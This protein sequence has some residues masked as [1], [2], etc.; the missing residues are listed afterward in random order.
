MG[1]VNSIIKFTQPCCHS[2]LLLASLD[3]LPDRFS[4]ENQP[5]SLLDWSN[6]THKPS[7]S[8]DLLSTQLKL[9]VANSSLIMFKTQG[10]CLLVDSILNKAWLFHYDFLFLPSVNCHPCF[11]TRANWRTGFCCCLFWGP[12]LVAHPEGRKR[13]LQ[14]IHQWPRIFS[15]LLSYTFGTLRS[16]WTFSNSIEP[17]G[18]PIGIFFIY[19]PTFYCLRILS[20]FCVSWSPFLSRW[21]TNLMK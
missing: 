20:A 14:P 10:I 18:W 6:W 15:L 17:V 1:E 9:S 13:V 3:P 4:F 12:E 8:Y 16:I 7:S 5:S 19:Q 21:C 2:R 11:L